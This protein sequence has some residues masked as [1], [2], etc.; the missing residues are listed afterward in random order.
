MK[1]KILNKKNKNPFWLIRD[2]PDRPLFKD[3][4]VKPSEETIAAA[5]E[6]YLKLGEQPTYISAYDEQI[7]LEWHYYK[8]NGIKKELYYTKELVVKDPI[9][10]EWRTYNY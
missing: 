1:N 2:M 5:E 3:C 10:M 9:N 6:I 7:I 8:K 4:P